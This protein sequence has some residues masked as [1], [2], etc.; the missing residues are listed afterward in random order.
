M[1]KNKFTSVF[2]DLDP[3]SVVN[4]KKELEEL[5][6][7]DS[8]SF[9]VEVFPE[10]VQKIISDCN[11]SLGY[12]ID[13]TA[14]SILY[15][16]SV[17]IGN[18]FKAEIMEQFQVNAVLYLAI[19]GRAGTA[20]SHPLRFALSPIEKRDNE[21]YFLYKEK[22]KEHQKALNTGK[23]KEGINPKNDLEKPSWKQFLVSD[24]TPEALVSVL[25]T[26]KR[27][28]GVYVDELATWFN[29]FNRYNKGSEEQF[30][31][32]NWSGSPLRVNRKTSDPINIPFPFISVA[33]TIQPSVLDQLT[34]NRTENG[35]TDRILFVY[36][37]NLKKEYWSETQ[38]SSETP[39]E[40]SAILAHLLDFP[41][42]FDEAEN[43]KPCILKFSKEAREL[44]FEWNRKN[45]DQSNSCDNDAESAICAK[46]EQYAIR[47]SLI[48]QLLQ[49]ACSKSEYNLIDIEAVNGA[50]KLA[51]YFKTTAIR[52]QSTISNEYSIEQLPENKRL[53]YEAL[54]DQ[55]LTDEGVIISKRFVHE[56]TFKR[57]L[58]EKNLFKKIEWG[59]YQKRF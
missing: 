10:S 35:F 22:A 34:K 53:L 38:L 20:K 5:L 55:F 19:V 42:Q 31:L 44:L 40:W 49:N 58:K 41:Q 47:F 48:L 7:N 30:W 50:T 29:N 27:G 3:E 6:V 12:P 24:F 2:D 51:E 54:P 57:F 56:R 1:A 14:A 11:K 32:S 17:S 23:K 46:I 33:G 15:A 28:L 52:I 43:P 25:Q 36:P 9:P 13:F 4:H 16:V 59:K 18:T 21:A 37:E 26:N 39:K 8:N 45:T